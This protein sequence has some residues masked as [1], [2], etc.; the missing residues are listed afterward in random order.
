MADGLLSPFSQGDAMGAFGLGLL[1][2][3]QDKQ[4]NP[5]QN[6]AYWSMQ[7]NQPQTAT[8][9]T[10]PFQGVNPTY[11][12]P[13]NSTDDAVTRLMQSIGH[14]ESGNRYTELGPRTRSGDRA[15]GQYQVMG[16]NIPSWTK[17]ILGVS[18]TPEQFLT[19]KNAQDAVAKAKL[20]GYL[21]QYGNINDAASMWFSGRPYKNNQAKDVL[22]TSVPQ[23][24]ATVN[25]YYGGV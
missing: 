3:S 12:L 17:E 9:E 11:T 22:G 2:M 1:N 18:M 23:Y 8:P 14:L 4:V 7:N 16:A 24:V 25:K 21:K 19:D 10:Q 13:M 5:A 20:G 15:Y 6:L